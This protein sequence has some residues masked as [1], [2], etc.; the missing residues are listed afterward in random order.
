MSSPP[1]PRPRPFARRPG[2]TL[3]ELLAVIAV[4]A[5]LVALLLPAVQQA[6]EA[7]RRA[8][9]L[10]NLHQVALA[11]HNYE[12]LHRT[13]PIGCDGCRLT[14]FPPPPGFRL[15]R[16]AW[17]V[18]LLPFLDA[19]PVADRFDTDRPHDDAANLAAAGTVLP[20]F[21][22]PSADTT[23]RP[24]PTTGDRNGNGRHDPGDGLAWTDYGG[25]YGV[26]FDT[27][28]ILPEHEGVLLY[29]RA[30]RTAQVRDGLTQTAAV[31]ECTGRGLKFQSE[32]A[33]G[34]NLFDHRFN[35]P[36][37]RSRNNELYS[38]HPGGV[39]VAFCDGHAGFLS[40]SLDQDVLNALLTRAG[41]ELVSFP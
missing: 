40:E 9:C 16:I 13:L 36:V 3:I 10:N 32:W 20:A 30:I 2:F 14:A 31:G 23:D 5:V 24:G 27:P 38:D 15:K 21:L 17:T 34:H 1:P 6:R 41:G 33:N 25:L 11:I 4:I 8:A 7:A 19:G 39:H 18:G 26:S 28:A 29:D 35:S 37:N 12:S 22:C